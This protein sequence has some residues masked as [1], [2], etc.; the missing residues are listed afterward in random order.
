MCAGK[1]QGSS[2]PAAPNIGLHDADQMEQ[3]A[4]IQ[5]DKKGIL[6]ASPVGTAWDPS[7]LWAHEDWLT[8]GCDREEKNSLTNVVP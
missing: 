7:I 8:A 1:R 3:T 6:L 4:S 2:R 5:T